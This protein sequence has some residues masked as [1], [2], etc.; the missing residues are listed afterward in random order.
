MCYN[1]VS[2]CV[3]LAFLVFGF[4]PQLAVPRFIPG[5]LLRDH[6]CWGSGDLVGC[7]SPNP[8]CP[9]HGERSAPCCPGTSSVY[10]FD[11]C[12][13]ASSV[14]VFDVEG[15]PVFRPV[16][17]DRIPRKRG[18]GVSDGLSRCWEQLS[19]LGVTQRM[20]VPAV[21]LVSECLGLLN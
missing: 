5:S 14:Y 9:R 8:G 11:A 15:K 4:G 18:G 7:Q 16:V 20:P 17:F 21:D 13:N 6:L 10:I 2:I 1:H 12:P 3:G 19:Q